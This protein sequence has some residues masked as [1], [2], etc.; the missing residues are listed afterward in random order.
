MGSD[1]EE[2]RT[3][4]GGVQASLC[5]AW[6]W[7]SQAWVQVRLTKELL[8]ILMLSPLDELKPNLRLGLGFCVL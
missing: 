5:R 8:T 7:G 6:A 4:G 2:P 3:R 1:H